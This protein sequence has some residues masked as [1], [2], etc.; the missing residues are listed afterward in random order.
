MK[1]VNA[2]VFIDGAFV[3]GGVEFTD[4]I[5]A[6]GAD[7]TGDTGCCGSAEDGLGADCPAEKAAASETA[8]AGVI[9]CGG[10]YIIPGFVDIHTHAAVDE[11]ASD[12]TI[13][14]L[15]KMSLYYA[16]RGVTSWCPT[17][18][19]LSEETLTKAVKAAAAFKRPENG[20]KVA[21][22][23]LEGPFINIEKK[24]AQNGEFVKAPDIDM[25]NRLYDASE[26]LVKLIT[27]AP[28]TEGAIEF[29]KEASKKVTVSLGHT[30]ADYDTAMKAYEAG[31]RHTTHLYNAMPSL[32]HRKPGVIAAASDAGATV[33]LIVD[34]FHSH[35]S[36]VRLTQRLF[37]DKLVMISDS[38]RCSGMPDGE[39]ELGGLP[40]TMIN[41]KAVL[42]GTDTLAG[43]TI[44][45]MDGFLRGIKFG[46]PIE[47]A[48]EATTIR[49][50]RVIGA[51]DKIGSIAPG[52]C[53]DLIVLTPDLDIV[54]VYID[55]RPIG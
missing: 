10:A 48:V 9:D 47:E 55:G 32:H 12:G 26:G 37:A 1:L 34:G 41:G 50:A 40:I 36:V 29:I 16:A 27:V 31:A 42:T 23:N 2:K 35:P 24:G 53:A 5:Q 49:P 6:A 28:E 52:K 45:L 8:E 33:E 25:F 30:D 15:E 7:V 44:H 19:T 38:A 4:V 3:D 54:D 13:E 14:G 46:I 51:D 21:G 20:A 17:T 11:D 18:M 22:I 43:S 39:Y